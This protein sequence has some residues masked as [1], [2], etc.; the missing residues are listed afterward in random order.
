MAK[1]KTTPRK[2]RNQNKKQTT[3][4]HHQNILKNQ[5]KQKEKD[6]MDKKSFFPAQEIEWRQQ[7]Q[8]GSYSQ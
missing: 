6:E 5:K 4:T 1:N 7:K 3:K 8:P 2:G